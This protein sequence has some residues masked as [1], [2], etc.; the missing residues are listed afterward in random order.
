MALGLWL[1]A[2]P[3][4]AP[5][6]TQDRALA[7]LARGDPAGALAELRLAPPAAADAQ[8]C[9][10]L[11]GLLLHRLQRDAEAV[12]P[13]QRAVARDGGD[14][15][16]RLDLGQALLAGGRW[17]LAQAQFEA[18]RALAPDRAAPWGGLGQL[19]AGRA[20]WDEAALNYQRAADLDPRAGPAW[21]GLADAR[22]KQGRLREAAVARQRAVD[23]GGA[24]AD[25]LFK[26][27]VAWYGL[28]E[29]DRAA[30]ALDQANLGD[31]P[32]AFFL[33]GCLQV[34]RGG[35]EAAQRDFLAAM[36]SQGGYPQA[37]LNLGIAYFH[38]GRYDEALA[39]F[40]QLIQI[41]GLPEAESYRV[42]A[43]SAASD[44]YFRL[45]SQALLA[46][47]LA[48]A[49]QPLQRAEALAV[50]PDRPALQALIG[51][52]QQEEGPAAVSL[53]QQGARALLSGGLA[54]AVL[55][56]QQA[57]RLDPALAS[58]QHG[59]SGSQGD[60]AALELAYARAA[61]QA[62]GA[63]DLSAA[64]A[65]VQR[66]SKLD[67][68]AG[69]TLQDSLTRVRRGRLQACLA[70]GIGDLEAGHPPLAL[71]QFD[72]ALALDPRDERALA[73]R[74]QAQ[75]ALR[76]Q[77]GALLAAAREAEAQGHNL[78]ALE[79]VR[80]ALA[81]DPEDLEARQFR[82][83]L[84]LRLD[85][86]R[87]GALQADDLYYQGVYAYGAGDTV[88]ALELWHAGLRL[89]PTDGP[90]LAAVHNADLKLKSLMALGA[91]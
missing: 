54:Q 68:A 15:A 21:L 61:A 6:A 53:S 87:D 16:A 41:G 50:G 48:G 88:R 91:H 90:L 35:W 66:L 86:K 76:T 7:L 84:L 27:A 51:R 24:D 2:C 17:D 81:A 80:E 1:A 52:V 85:L 4:L 19:A 67:H 22:L 78:P 47:D 82:Q 70:A 44:H 43:A 46:G 57:L 14:L 83:R 79:R 45:G 65:L 37:Q 63:G 11:E 77:V 8:G 62:D 42:E 18:A 38:Q 36:A 69:Q 55:L 58:A 39:Q 32:E 59:L 31:R 20:R 49:L 3:H 40:D 29:W 34:Q 60:L 73:R 25:L 33:S 26:Q 75:A 89:T 28:G 10:L 30:L 5:A 72:R 9:D 12:A 71:E 23:L 13:L 56:W 64:Q 74:A